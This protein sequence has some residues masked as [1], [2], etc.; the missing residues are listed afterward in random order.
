VQFLDARR[1]W[2]AGVNGT[3]IATTNGGN[4]WQPQPSNSTQPLNDIFFVNANEGWAAGE[5]GALLHT[6]DGG[7][8]W[9]DE[10]LKTFASLNKLYFIAPNCGWVVGANGSIYKFSA[11]AETPLK[12]TSR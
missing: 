1:G 7:A 12:G 5:R 3:I 9:Q 4:R 6:R 10:S 8:T 2:A 11:N